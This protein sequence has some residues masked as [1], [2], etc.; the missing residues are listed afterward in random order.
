[1]RVVLAPRPDQAVYAQDLF[2]VEL[3]LCYDFVLLRKGERSYPIPS[4]SIE[5]LVSHNPH[6]AADAKFIQN[7]DRGIPIVVHVH[8][9]WEYLT[10]EEQANLALSL[11]RATAAIVPADFLRDTL[12]IKFPHVVWYTVPNGVKRNLYFPSVQNDRLQF[13]RKR[14]IPTSKKLIGY[15]GRLTP[16]KGLTVLDY[17]CKNISSID[18]CALVQFPYWHLQSQENYLHHARQ[19]KAYDPQNVFYFADKGPRLTSRSKT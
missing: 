13:R 7:A 14:R 10:A 12:A 3:S 9:Q 17:V 6:E 18:A 16:A 19:M 8:Y 1:M 5:L 15:I 11:A 4:G 2:V